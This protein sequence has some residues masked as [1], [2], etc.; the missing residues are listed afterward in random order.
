MFG[1]NK[2]NLEEIQ[3]RKEEL[4]QIV[5][6]TAENSTLFEANSADIENSQRQMQV[7]MKQVSDN[8]QATADQAGKSIEE[9]SN[10]SGTICGLAENMQA[11]EEEYAGIVEQIRKQ[12]DECMALVEENKHFTTPSKFINEAPNDLHGCNKSYLEV[13]S[14]IKEYSKQIG[15]LALNAAIEAGRMG[16]SGKQF[17]AA[18]ESIRSF[19]SS[20]DEVVEELGRIVGESDKKIDELAEHSHHLVGLL[21][22]NN[23]ATNKLFKQNQLTVRMVDQASIRPFS[24]D[25]IECKEQLTGI[26]NA[27]EEI[28]KLQ[29]RSQIQMEDIESEIRAQ[30]KASLELSDELIPMFGHAKEYREKGWENS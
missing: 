24:G 2:V 6:E 25:V 18:A 20:F 4:E 1:K 15:V 22:N 8:I 13:M 23:V 27:E 21:K 28:L 29:E 12:T 3:R 11:A 26:R 30:K 5:E 16:E 9:V 14:Q 10:L 7:N 19:T 17:V